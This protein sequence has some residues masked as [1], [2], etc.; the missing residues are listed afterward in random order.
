MLATVPPTG[1]DPGE[2]AAV[3]FVIIVL[4]ALVLGTSFHAF[5]QAASWLRRMGG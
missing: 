4:I 1:R 3:L 5:G 2:R